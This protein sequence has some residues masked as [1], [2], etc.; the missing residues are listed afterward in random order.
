[1]QKYA[2]YKQV[3]MERSRDM[4]MECGTAITKVVRK[5]QWN[6]MTSVKQEFFYFFFYNT[7]DKAFRTDTQLMMSSPWDSKA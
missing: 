3:N 4:V 2:T 5:V 7:K 6:L 1:M